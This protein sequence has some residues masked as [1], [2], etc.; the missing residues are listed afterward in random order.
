MLRMWRAFVFPTLCQERGFVSAVSYQDARSMPATSIASTAG[1]SPPHR[2]SI[3]PRS[4]RKG[5]RKV[6]WGWPD[7]TSE[8][9][10]RRAIGLVA[11]SDLGAV[12]RHDVRDFAHGE[13]ISP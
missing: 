1:C 7:E 12:H 2:S 13:L 9:R 5:R 6:V 8:R 11:S 3:D 4:G 10:R